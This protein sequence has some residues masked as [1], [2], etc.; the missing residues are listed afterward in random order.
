MIFDKHDNL[1]IIDSGNKRGLILDS[2]MNVITSFGESENLYYP[3][4]IYVI[5][6]RVLNKEYI[7]ITDYDQTTF[8]GRVIRYIYDLNTHEVTLDKEM[9]TPSSWILEVDNYVY[10]PIKIAVSEN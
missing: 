4:G 5:D 8:D 3:R 9:H 1:Y 2:S 6:S 7:Y 10:K